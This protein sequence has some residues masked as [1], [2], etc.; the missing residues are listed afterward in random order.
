MQFV[1]NVGIGKSDRKLH[2]SFKIYFL[3]VEHLGKTHI[4]QPKKIFI[5]C[6]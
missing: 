5:A 2:L 1:D 4:F 6:I 3:I